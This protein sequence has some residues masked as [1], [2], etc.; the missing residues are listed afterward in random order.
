MKC[1]WKRQLLSRKRSD[2]CLMNPYGL[3]G[4]G[5]RIRPSIEYRRRMARRKFKR[6]PEE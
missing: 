3:C 1:E 2:W 5:T 6:I 4:C